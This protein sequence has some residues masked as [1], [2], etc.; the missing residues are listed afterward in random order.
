MFAAHP[1]VRFMP[2]TGFL[3]RYVANGVLAK[4]Y[5]SGG[6]V[7]AI[8][9]LES[10]EPFS[11]TGMDAGSL[12]TRALQSGE[13]LDVA[14]YRR[15]VAAYAWADCWGVGDKD[16]RAI[17]FLP[18]LARI[19]P[20][21]KVIHIVRDPRDVLVSKKTASWSR[22]HHP[23]R[24]IFANRVQM[25]L[26]RE[27]GPRHFGS[28]Y[29]ELLYEDLIREPDAVLRGLCARIGLRFDTA[30]LSFGEAA[31][32]LVAPAEL[33]WKSETLGPLLQENTNKWRD[34]LPDR[35]RTLTERCCT[36]ARSVGGYFTKDVATDLDLID[37]IWVWSGDVAIRFGDPLYRAYR[38]RH[39]SRLC[40]NLV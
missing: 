18:L 35:E 3:R 24:H 22:H 17:E 9:R 29:H 13:P 4:L 32:R 20:A 25:R 34:K 8:K 2:E 31:K 1:A 37:R 38:N 21:A 23:W 7:A 40:R 11:R 33:S 36:E 28:N 19:F 16:P 30:M 39:V 27:T 6:R 12:L 15:L 14:V 5:R 10:D 26:G